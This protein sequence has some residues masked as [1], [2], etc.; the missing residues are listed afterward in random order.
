MFVNRRRCRAC[1]FHGQTL[2]LGCGGCQ[3]PIGLAN[4]LLDQVDHA[5][6]QGG[7]KV[8]LAR[9]DSAI[10]R[11]FLECDQ[12]AAPG[13]QTQLGVCDQKRLFTQRPLFGFG[14]EWGGEV[15]FLQKR[16]PF[17][18]KICR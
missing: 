5:M 17:D 6:H 18:S 15:G 9:L 10:H 3:S 12:Q 11:F 1:G 2:N 4:A 8:Q 13:L 14:L 7:L 16:I